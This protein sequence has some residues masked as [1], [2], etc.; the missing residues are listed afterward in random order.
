MAVI[1]GSEFSIEGI[2]HRLQVFKPL[3]GTGGG[4]GGSYT[5]MSVEWDRFSLSKASAHRAM[6]V[7]V[8]LE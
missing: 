1:T 5:T 7:A 8:V 2:E 3:V 4:L 6:E